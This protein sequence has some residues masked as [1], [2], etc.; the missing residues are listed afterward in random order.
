MYESQQIMIGGKK[1]RTKAFI[2][3]II[4]DSVCTTFKKQTKQCMV[5]EFRVVVVTSG[6]GVVTRRGQEKGF[7]GEKMSVSGGYIGVF[8]L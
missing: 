6:Q 4:Y 7:S 1:A 2:E 3:Q 8:I 5:T